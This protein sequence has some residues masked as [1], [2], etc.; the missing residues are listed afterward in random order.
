MMCLTST[1]NKTEMETVNKIS[2]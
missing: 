1:S 2:I